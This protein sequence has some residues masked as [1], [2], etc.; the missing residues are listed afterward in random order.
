[1]VEPFLVGPEDFVDGCV[2]AFTAAVIAVFIAAV[3]AA[4]RCAFPTRKDIIDQEMVSVFED[5][6]RV[7]LQNPEERFNEVVNEFGLRS[8]DIYGVNYRY[9]Q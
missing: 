7:F 8:V 9:R 4:R 5:R 2:V 1:M 6:V 3:V